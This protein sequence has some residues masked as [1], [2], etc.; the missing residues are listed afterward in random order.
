M[1]LV[2]LDLD[3]TLLN[4]AAAM[5]VFMNTCREMGLDADLAQQAF[6]EK[7]AAKESFQAL[8]FLRPQITE[9]QMQHF[10]ALYQ[11]QARYCK[12]FVYPDAQKLLQ[13]LQESDIDILLLTFGEHDWQSL[14]IQAAELSHLP[15]SIVDTTEKGHII[16]RWYDQANRQFNV[17]TMGQ[18]YRRLIFVD[19]KPVSFRGFPERQSSGFIIDR[20]GSINPNNAIENITYIQSLSEVTI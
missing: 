20:T 12:D 15:V 10:K 19:D 3:R 4:L 2:V 7:I 13:Q 5:N 17:P 14:K 18:A 9:S 6:E 11:E 16:S 8:E 1:K